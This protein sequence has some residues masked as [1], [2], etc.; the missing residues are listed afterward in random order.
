MRRYPIGDHPAL[1]VMLQLREAGYFSFALRGERQ[2]NQLAFGSGV[3]ASDTTPS[4]VASLGSAL[5]G[6]VCGA[7]LKIMEI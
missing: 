3:S 5:N 1:K 6:Y 7:R 2:Y 4:D